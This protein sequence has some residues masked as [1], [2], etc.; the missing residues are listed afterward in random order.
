HLPGAERVHNLLRLRRGEGEPIR[1]HAS[2]VPEQL[3]P[4]LPEHDAA[5][6]QLC[7]IL[8]EHFDLRMHEGTESLE[9]VRASAQGSRLLGVRLV[10]PL[11]LLQ[12]S[13]RNLDGVPFEY[14]R[15]VCRGDRSRL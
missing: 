6:P 2:L 1:L 14:S 11:L 8:E 5:G 7:V 15:I 3:A 9:S 4:T 12:Q 10:S 13:I